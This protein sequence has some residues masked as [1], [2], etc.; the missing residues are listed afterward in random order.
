MFLMICPYVLCQIGMSSI[1]DQQLYYIS[2]NTPIIAGQDLQ[3]GGTWMGVTPQGRWA[4][5]TNFR[6]GRDQNHMKL[7]GALS[8]GFLE[9][10][11]LPIRFAQ[12]LEQQQQNFAGFN[13]FMGNA[14]QAVYMSNRGEARKY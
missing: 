5:L 4:V 11:L 10:D 12:Q 3:S 2:G 1:I 13:L 8:S 14:D 7:L 9:S 6:D